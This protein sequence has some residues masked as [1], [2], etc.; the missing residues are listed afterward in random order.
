MMPKGESLDSRYVQVPQ[1]KSRIVDPQLSPLDTKL[2]VD[3]KE[4]GSFKI[5]PPRPAPIGHSN[6]Y[7]LE[8]G[9]REMHSV[10]CFALFQLP[11]GVWHTVTCARASSQSREVMFQFFEEAQEQRRETMSLFYPDEVLFFVFF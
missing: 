4:T 2:Q 11:W 6:T 3:A 9:R 5:N 10:D 7:I 8:E 1:R